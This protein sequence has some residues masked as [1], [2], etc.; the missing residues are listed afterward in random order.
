MNAVSQSSLLVFMFYLFTGISGVFSEN[1]RYL[2]A[3][4]TA[5][6]HQRTRSK[7]TPVPKVS[8][9]PLP[10][11][12]H[13]LVPLQSTRADVERLLGKPQKIRYSTYI[14]DTAHDRIDILY[15]QGR[16]QVSEVERWNV[17]KDVIIRIDIRPKH[18]LL[19]RTLNLD[20]NRYVRIRESHP[21]NWSTYSNKEDGVS[22]EAIQSG[23]VE[24]VNSITYGPKAK[25]Q[26]L[27][28]SR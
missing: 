2:T 15:S 11:N 25:D 18:T 24:E 12:W 28:C 5:I 20:R 1:Q 17:Q 19:V 21:N 7:S 27:R 6:A 16:C 14:Y 26:S 10:N 9:T 4:R 8:P 13:G 23:R 3:D 22:V